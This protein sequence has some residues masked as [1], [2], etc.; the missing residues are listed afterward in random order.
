MIME[1]RWTMNAMMLKKQ[2]ENQR[3]VKPES[4][5]NQVETQQMKASLNLLKN[6]IQTRIKSKIQTMK[7]LRQLLPH[8]RV[9]NTTRVKKS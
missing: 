4:L 3:N 9:L 2:A 7:L 6:L 5:V 8:Q 1:N